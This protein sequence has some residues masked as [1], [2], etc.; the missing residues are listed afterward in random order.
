MVAEEDETQ[1]EAWAILG[2]GE[3]TA[4]R[5]R[6]EF[7]EAAGLVDGGAA[8]TAAAAAAPSGTE[9]AVLQQQDVV[10]AVERKPDEIEWP[11]ITRS[12]CT[13][14]CTV[15]DASGSLTLHRLAAKRAPL[16]TVQRC[17]DVFPEA[18]HERTAAGNLA[19]DL[20]V[21]AGAEPAVVDKLF[22]GH[23]QAMGELDE[24]KSVLKNEGGEER[25]LSHQAQQVLAATAKSRARLC[26]IDSVEAK[27]LGLSI[28]DRRLLSELIAGS[29]NLRR[30]QERHGLAADSADPADSEPDGPELPLEL[31]LKHQAPGVVVARLLEEQPDAHGTAVEGHLPLHWAVK[32]KASC[33]VVDTLLASQPGSAAIKTDAYHLPAG[34]AAAYRDRASHSVSGQHIGGWPSV[35]TRR[36]LAHGE[37]LQG[38]AP[39]S[40]SSTGS[41]AGS[42]AGSVTAGEG[43]G[44]VRLTFTD[45]PM[46]VKWTLP[47]SCDEPFRCGTYIASLTLATAS[48]VRV[49]R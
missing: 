28:V 8:A 15:P 47:R 20:A 42:D 44:S 25:G 34:K 18:L 14:V 38:F 22:V 36:S 5:L 17:L 10:V 45:G 11:L 26:E 48:A 41:A 3:S 27:R 40:A 12:L 19:Y 33:E 31:A 35:E 2:G 4:Q 49:A 16:Q 24:L 30:V 29:R 7:A 13:E 39:W 23:L 9:V 46:G 37:H 1:A 6:D 43:N 21:A 32:H